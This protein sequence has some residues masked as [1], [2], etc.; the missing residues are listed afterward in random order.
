MALLLETPSLTT[1]ENLQK[2]VDPIFIFNRKKSFMKNIALN[3][4]EVFEKTALKLFKSNNFFGLL[5]L[6][7]IFL[8]KINI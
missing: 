5:V 8:G 1:F 3:L 7:F 4:Q 2:N 6:I